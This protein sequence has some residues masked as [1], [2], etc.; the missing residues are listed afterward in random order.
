[1]A[2][3]EK[4]KD[5][6]VELKLEIQKLLSELPGLI[7]EIEAEL[8]KRP[9][10]ILKIDKGFEVFRGQPSMYDSK[11]PFYNPTSDSRYGDL[12][13][14]IG[15]W[16][17]AGS[18]EVAI[19]ETF[20]HG[21]VGP[22]TPVLRSEIEGCSLHKLETARVLRLVNVERLST[23]MG[24][25]LR[26]LVKAKGQGSEG[27]LRTQMLSAAIMRLSIKVDGLY[28]GSTVFPSPG[29]WDGCNFALF[30]GRGPQLSPVSI[31][32]LTEVLLASDETAIELLVGLKVS[33]E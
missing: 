31:T 33:I 13:K 30:D 2:T 20:Q 5:Y 22:G 9:E 10:L 16:Y 17:V 19:A 6:D 18:R 3:E 32:P 14:A 29:S 15:V 8:S 11:P 28:Y 4:E 26:D 1:M 12:W 7:V 23:Y 27:Y 21:R 24:G 25:K